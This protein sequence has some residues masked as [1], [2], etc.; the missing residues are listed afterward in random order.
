MERIGG[1][2]GLGLSGSSP[3]KASSSPP[4]PPTP[5]RV[6]DEAE[7]QGFVL[8]WKG[9]GWADST[10]APREDNKGNSDSEEDDDDEYQA[11]TPEEEARLRFWR[12]LVV[13]ILL[14]ALAAAV[15][16]VLYREQMRE[17]FSDIFKG[18]NATLG[19]VLSVMFAVGLFLVATEDYTGIN[20]SAVMM[21]AA[22]TM[23]T[24]HAIG[25]NPN[26]SKQGEHKLTH[27]INEGIE[28]VGS[29][30]LFLLPAMALVESIDHFEG[31]AIVTHIIEK[32]MAGNR[33]MLI[34]IISVLTFFLSSVI[35]N[36]TS[37]IVSLKLLHHVAR[38]DKEW[39]KFCGGAVVVASNAGGTW[40]PIG[41]V[42]TIM[43]WI[44]GKITVNN[45]IIW[46]IFPS[47][48]AGL[49]P[50]IGIIFHSR[51]VLA[52]RDAAKAALSDAES[53]EVRRNS[54]ESPAFER[55]W[56]VDAPE[57][58]PSEV[59]A[60]NIQMFA[61]GV[62][63]ILSVPVLK[64]ITGLEPWLGML[65][66]L[67]LMWLITDAIS[68][69]KDHALRAIGPPQHGVVEALR[70]VDLCGLLFFAGVLLA[71]GCLNAAG[72]LQRFAQQLAGWCGGSEVL[73]SS[74]LGVA[75][76]IVDN[77]PLVAASIEMFD[78]VPV[79]DKLWQLI[80]LASSTGG[81]LTSVGSIAGVTFMNMEGISFMWYIKYVTVWAAVG[82][83][84]G[85][86]A[87]QAELTLFGNPT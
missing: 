19:K 66:A 79:D 62:S 29:V 80:A 15:A 9:D 47:L 6:S 4:S 7:A 11:M 71:V 56:T 22:S 67:G 45:T 51:Y 81:S 43:L 52:A 24:V 1:S 60:H 42:T 48:V 54:N 50:M 46:L 83:A 86:F 87:Y 23:W 13:I 57:P 28:D 73:L 10:V 31:F 77:V 61:M 12:R 36:L 32:G 55:Q 41:D 44:Q 16:S 39:R 74:M 34:P 35:D 30:I 69:E 3:T 58:P 14:L 37:T 8:S 53:S 2:I 5:R 72:V 17:F 33:E 27:E 75:S 64:A 20:K 49:L 82:F 25:Y 40:S 70:K 65:L 21:V 63:C 85:I 78:D 18:D 76:A 26:E 84:A 68:T 38:E 59:N